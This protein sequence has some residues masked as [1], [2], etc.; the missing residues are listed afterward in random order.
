MLW[1]PDLDLVKGCG[2]AAVLVMVLA[3][4]WEEAWVGGL[5]LG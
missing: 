1:G 3:M 2:W 5:A 4:V